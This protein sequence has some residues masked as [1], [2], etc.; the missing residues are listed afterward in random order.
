MSSA[1][2][3]TALHSPAAERNSQ[4]IQDALL[5]WLPAQGVALEIAS[6][7]GQHIA[8]FSAQMPGWDWLAS[9][10]SAAALA[11]I[12]AWRPQGPAPL[13]LDVRQADW[14]L[15][16]SHHSLDALYC[17]NMLHISAWSTCA[18]LMQGAAR[19]LA[20][21]GLALVYGPFLQTGFD[22]AASNLAFDADLKRRDPAWGLRHLDDV[23][24]VALGCG[25]Q[26]RNRLQMPANNLLLAF[27][28]TTSTP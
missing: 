8:H 16:A 6:G 4:V 10:P 7:S 25:L 3:R 12:S 11:S 15:P 27:S 19:H 20:P 24:A 13:M 28:K 22:T 21:T 14:G 17:A 9:D 2:P 5:Q 18:A 1:L 23:A 26:L